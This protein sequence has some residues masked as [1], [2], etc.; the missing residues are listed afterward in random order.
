MAQ[1]IRDPNPEDPSD[2]GKQEITDEEWSVILAQHINEIR[3]EQDKPPV[4]SDI[5]DATITDAEFTLIL[6]RV[7]PS[8]IRG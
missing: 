1:Y 2:K 8:I 5:I 7:F 6:K 3:L 4:T